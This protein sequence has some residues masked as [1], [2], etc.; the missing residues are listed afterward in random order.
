MAETD[1]G[2]LVLDLQRSRRRG[3]TYRQFF[4]R[5]GIAGAL[6]RVNNRTHGICAELADEDLPAVVVGDRLDHPKVSCVYSESRTASREA[7]EHLI[8]LGHRRIAISVNVVP[9]VDHE[10][11]VRG[12]SEALDES[13]IE[14][15]PKLV[16]SAPAH[17]VGG[18]TVAKR[19]AT[20]ADRPTAMY[21]TDP[22]AALGVFHEMAQLGINVPDDISI[23]GFDDT[24]Y[25]YF[26]NPTY[27]A[28]CQNTHALGQEAIDAL[29]KRISAPGAEPVRKAL[30]TWL[31]VHDSTGPAPAPRSEK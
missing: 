21:V 29:W 10:D 18:A 23:V 15:D 6:L 12:Y 8:G 22:M 13:G 2:L 27:T 26:I 14:F 28:V 17:R 31:E 24:E 3:E 25:R 5:M 1:Y 16:I 9:D 20:M 19:V 4:H 7:I 30:Q 11:R